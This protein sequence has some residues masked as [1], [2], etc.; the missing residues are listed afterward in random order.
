MSVVLHSGTL[1]TL[2]RIMDFSD[3]LKHC[4]RLTRAAFDKV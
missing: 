1:V 3:L 2:A 4:Y